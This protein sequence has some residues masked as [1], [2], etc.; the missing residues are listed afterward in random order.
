MIPS[1]NKCRGYRFSVNAYK[2]N[3]HHHRHL[4]GHEACL[5]VR[6]V[7]KAPCDVSPSKRDKDLTQG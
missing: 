5:H 2:T 1:T 7:S 3:G 4:R 6:A